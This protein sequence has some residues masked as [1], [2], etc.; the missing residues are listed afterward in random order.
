MKETSIRLRLTNEEKAA[1]AEA[2]R[3]SGRDL[4]NWAR[5]V[6]GRAARLANGRAIGPESPE[7]PSPRASD[8]NGVTHPSA[9]K[10]WWDKS[11]PPV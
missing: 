7:V 2:A 5:W 8:V 4:S 11:K 10:N 9:T 6:M 1:F 3:S